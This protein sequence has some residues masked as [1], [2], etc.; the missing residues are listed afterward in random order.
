MSILVFIKDEFYYAALALAENGVYGNYA[1]QFQ[2][3]RDSFLEKPPMV[4]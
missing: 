1:S 3:G 4:D 2:S